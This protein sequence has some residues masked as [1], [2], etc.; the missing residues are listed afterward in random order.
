[1][2]NSFFNCL[3]L[4]LESLWFSKLITSLILLN[5]IILGAETYDYLHNS[6]GFAFQLADQVILS[7]FVCEIF[8]RLVVYRFSFFKDPWSIF[9]S[10]VIILA[11]VPANE[12]FSVLRAV[13]VLRVLR[14][15]SF[16]PR[17]KKVIEGLLNAIPGLGS[18]GA[19]LII[20]FYVFSVMATKL[21]GTDFPQWFGTLHISFFSLFQIMTLEGWADMVREIMKTHPYSWVFFVIYILFATFTVLNLFIAVIVDAMQRQHHEEEFA[22]AESLKRIEASITKIERKLNKLSQTSK[23]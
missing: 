11:L 2:N 19:I 20:V 6:W 5:A 3:R 1:M 7:I 17:L 12:A 21:Y 10:L 23:N 16:F 14:L 9:D 13:R 8:L 22:E 15:I 18:I 4:T